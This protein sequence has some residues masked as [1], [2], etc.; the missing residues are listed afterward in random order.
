MKRALT[1]F[2]GVAVWVCIAAAQAPQAPAGGQQPG[3]PAPGGAAA[4]AGRG[5]GRAAITPRILSF[6]AKPASIKPGESVVLTWATEAGTPNIDNGV[7]EVYPR[8]TLKI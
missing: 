1:V 5:G 7:G 6:E 8:G 2:G 3:A 4:P